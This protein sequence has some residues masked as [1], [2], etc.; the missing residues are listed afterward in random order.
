MEN[1]N[2]ISSRSWWRDTIRLLR[3][4]KNIK[5]VFQDGTTGRALYSD[6]DVLLQIPGGTGQGV[7]SAGAHPFQITQ[8]SWLNISVAPGW[9]NVNLWPPVLLANGQTGATFLANGFN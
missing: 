3:S 2:V 8:A 9:L 6:D 7:S 5:L 4:L 1:V